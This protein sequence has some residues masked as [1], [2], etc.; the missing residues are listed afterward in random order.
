MFEVQ[1]NTNRSSLDN[2]ADSY[3]F[4]YVKEDFMA[5]FD[6]ANVGDVDIPFV[7]EGF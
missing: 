7:A 4:Q 6:W 3:R 1:R 5:V 2:Q